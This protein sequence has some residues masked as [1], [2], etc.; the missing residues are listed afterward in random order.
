MDSLV[1]RKHSDTDLRFAFL[2]DGKLYTLGL[3]KK[4]DEWHLFIGNPELSGEIKQLQEILRTL[5]KTEDMKELLKR[6][7]FHLNHIHF[8]PFD[9][10]DPEDVGHFKVLFD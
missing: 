1:V 10:E 2:Q 7:Q 3:K 5:S 8:H 9:F 4:E 6:E